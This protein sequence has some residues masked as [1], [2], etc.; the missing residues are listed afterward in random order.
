MNTQFDNLIRNALGA[1]L[2]AY[3]P[4]SRFAVGTAV[5][6][7]SGAV[8]IGSNIENISHGLTICAE[9]IGMGRSVVTGQTRVGHDRCGCG[10]D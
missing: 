2:Q 6:C 3:A 1:R 8:F 9:R 4:Y 10:H 7:K 5:Q